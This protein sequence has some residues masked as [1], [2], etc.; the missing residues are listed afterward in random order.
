MAFILTGCA[1]PLTTA[2]EEREEGSVYGV[3][4]DSFSVSH[5]IGASALAIMKDG[6]VIYEGVSGFMDAGHNRA[7]VSNVMMRVASVSKPSQP[8]LF[9]SWLLRGRWRWMRGPSILDSLKAECLICSHFLR[10]VIL[11]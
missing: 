5:G 7:I 8:L 1:D 3:T 6:N 2:P 9:V 4:L 11:G 10:S